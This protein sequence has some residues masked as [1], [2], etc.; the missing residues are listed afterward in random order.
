[1]NAIKYI[2][3]FVILFLLFGCVSDNE[4][5]SGLNSSSDMQENGSTNII[6]E[7]CNPICSADHD[8]ISNACVLKEGCTYDNPKCDSDYGCINNDCVLKQGCNYNNPQCDKNSECINNKCILKSG[9][10]YDNPPCRV[11]HNCINNQC[12]LKP[13][14]TYENP[15]CDAGYGCVSNQ[16]VQE[17]GCQYDN[18]PCGSDYD[19]IGNTCV[20]KHGCEYENPE[21]A[22]GYACIENECIASSISISGRIVDEIG[23]GI[24]GVT[25]QLTNQHI[26]ADGKIYRMY[27]LDEETTPGG[28]FYFSNSD[29]LEGD[30]SDRL[31]GP[32]Y[33]FF[34]TIYK[35]GYMDEFVYDYGETP[36][37]LSSGE[38]NIGEITLSELETRNEISEGRYTVKYYDG[39]DQCAEIAMDKLQEYYPQVRSIF[40]VEPYLDTTTFTFNTILEQGS[41]DWTGSSNGIWTICYPWTDNIGNQQIRDMWD[42][43]IPHE[44]A[45]HIQLYLKKPYWA[46]EGIAQYTAKTIGEDIDCSSEFVSIADLHGEDMRAYDSAACAF[47]MLEQEQP[48]FFQELLQTMTDDNTLCNR[49]SGYFIKTTMS[50]VYGSD[51][52][53][54]FVDNFGFDEETLDDENHCS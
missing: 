23:S 33:K 21:C 6:E 14:C 49:E 44:L 12:V 35:D 51:L 3:C 10:E 39:Q 16:C 50:D 54:Y 13:G 42:T 26:A 28:N 47:Y 1:M 30:L 32:P 46:E 43:A 20:V 37:E 25:V 31:D 29:I 53:D 17:Y 11:S 7:G 38:W 15:P 5:S 48:G 19:C 18:P 22:V 41:G 52:T 4:T 27:I 9:C 34:L 36:K 8:C 45:H 40:G 24:S 2:S